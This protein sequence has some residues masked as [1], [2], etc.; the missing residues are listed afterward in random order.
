[1][2]NLIFGTINSTKDYSNYSAPSVLSKE[3]MD[4]VSFSDQKLGDSKS[5]KKTD[6]KKE[7]K[8]SQYLVESV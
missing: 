5:E 2:A 4:K 6:E 8:K 3:M 1:M 7:I